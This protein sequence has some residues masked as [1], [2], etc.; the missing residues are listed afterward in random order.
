MTAR[1]EKKWFTMTISSKIIHEVSQVGFIHIF[2][3][4]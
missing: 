3:H 1:K 2:S 4:V